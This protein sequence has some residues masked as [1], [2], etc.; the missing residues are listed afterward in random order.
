MIKSFTIIND[1]GESIFLDIRKP[2]DTGFLISSV[3]GLTPPKADIAQS[4][5]ATYDG[6]EITNA[7]IASRNIVFTI[8]FYQD[9]TEKLSIEELRHKSYKYFPIKRKITIEI[10]NDSG[11]YRT[12]GTVEA[13]EIAIFTKTEGAQVS[14][15]CPDPFFWETDTNTF[16]LF[17]EV[18]NFEFPVEFDLTQEFSII[19]PKTQ[20][21]FNYDG[22]G[23]CGLTI[24]IY[25]NGTATNF[26]FYDQLTNGYMKLNSTMLRKKTGN[27]IIKGDHI[28][29]NTKKGE[30]S[31]KLIRNGVT[32]NI[33][34][35]IDTSSE[36]IQLHAG[37]NR[38]A[39][40]ATTGALKLEV[41]LKYQTNYLGV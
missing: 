4:Q 20:Y 9:N 40:L 29:I 39:Y 23:E 10:E 25:S 24:D 5:H 15:I 27:D 30:K 16:Y 17:D 6:S 36:W 12:T 31:A 41:C 33:I 28:I 32:Y 3:T 35:C 13:N 22:A 14:V 18:P 38:V 26:T 19:D 7:K 34:Q 37:L 11:I 2:E 8:V 21:E 1:R